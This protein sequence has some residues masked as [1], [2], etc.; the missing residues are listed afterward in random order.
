MYKGAFVSD[1][2]IH[3][4]NETITSFRLQDTAWQACPSSS[5]LPLTLNPQAVLTKTP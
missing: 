1:L 3:D 4:Q 2:P 5:C